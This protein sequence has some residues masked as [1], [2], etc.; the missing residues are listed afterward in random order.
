MLDRQIAGR[1]DP[2]GS[3]VDFHKW[4]AERYRGRAVRVTWSFVALLLAAVAV[5]SVLLIQLNDATNRYE[6]TLEEI[7]R[8]DERVDRVRGIA[9]GSRAT[10][11]QMARLTACLENRVVGVTRGI[12][13]LLENK[14]TIAT[15]LKRYAPSECP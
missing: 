12:H 10:D 11:K 13:D 8:L 9:T 7:D 14:I 3:D 1:V 6:A 15:Y 4:V 2:P 5:V